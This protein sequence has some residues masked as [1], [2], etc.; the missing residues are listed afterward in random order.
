MFGYIYKTTN[1]VNG[2]QYIGRK[3][4]SIFIPSYHGSGVHLLNAIAKYGKENFTTELLKECFDLND[5]IES[6]TQYI[7]LYDAVNDDNFY[8]HS[9]GGWNEGFLPGDANIAKLPENREKN[10]KSH[11]GK[12]MPEGFGEHQRQIHLGKPSGM[13]GKHHSEATRK[14]LSE[15]TRNY[16]LNRKDYNQVS[17]HH[18]GSKMMTD[19]VEQKWVYVDD[20]DE[21]LSKGWYIGSCKPRKR[22][23]VTQKSQL[24]HKN[25]GIQLRN[26][27]WVHKG[28]EKHQINQDELEIYLNNGFSLG[29][30]DK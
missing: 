7:K 25:K 12:K 6:E 15:G 10:S 8:N 11:K 28:T 29:M 5:L 21:M 24:A 9:Y 2:K 3:T 20:I 13:L 23:Q 30:K 26:T 4:S 1:L 27:V 18:K 19:G 22:K 14:I 17:E 16:N